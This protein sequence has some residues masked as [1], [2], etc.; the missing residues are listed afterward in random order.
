MRRLPLRIYLPL[1]ASPTP[2]RFPVMMSQSSALKLQK[3]L[4]KKSLDQLVYHSLI[5]DPRI[6]FLERAFIVRLNEGKSYFMWAD[7]SPLL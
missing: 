2:Q 6:I 4:K 3:Y 7:S 5:A 1:R